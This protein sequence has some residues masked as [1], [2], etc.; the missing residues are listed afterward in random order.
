MAASIF[1]ELQRFDTLLPAD[2][3]GTL[4]DLDPNLKIYSDERVDIWYAPLGKPTP[5][6]VIWILGITPGW[7]QMRIAYEGASAAMRAGAS[8]REAVARPKPQMAFA[9]SMRDNLIDML[10]QLKLPAHVAVESSRDLFGSKLLRT[11]SVLKYPVFT[12]GKNYTGSSPGPTKHAALLEMLDVLL[13]EDIRQ[14]GHCLIIPLGKAV[15]AALEHSIDRGRLDAE[16]ILRGFPHPSG[17]NGH[18]F[19]QFRDNRRRL[20]RQIDRWFAGTAA[21]R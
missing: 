16:R 7:R 17:A 2:P 10:D 3:P 19:R 20:K 14:A 18:R 15:E 21:R 12:N 9:G 8:A 1:T 11:G 4:A 5:E 13:A 6:P